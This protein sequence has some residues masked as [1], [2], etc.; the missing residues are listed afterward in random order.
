MFYYSKYGID[1][2]DLDKSA[3]SFCRSLLRPV[4]MSDHPLVD[5]LPRDIEPDE[6]KPL[7]ELADI[8]KNAPVSCMAATG[9]IIDLSAMHK[10]GFWFQQEY[11]EKWLAC[12]IRVFGA[13]ILATGFEDYADYVT[14]G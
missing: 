7:R 11:F 13:D 6:V 1:P 8:L 14:Y 4:K 12:M 3:R 9:N 2:D 5:D 10:V